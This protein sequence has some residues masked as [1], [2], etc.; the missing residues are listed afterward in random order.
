MDCDHVREAISAS[1][2]GAASCMPVGAV[3]AHLAG[4][5]GC[6]AWREAAHALT[7]H[8][9][10]G[11]HVLGHD[12]TEAVLAAA[13]AWPSPPGRGWRLG[14]WV[15]PRARRAALAAVA[16]AQFAITVPL[17]VLGRDPG[18]GEH[19][20]HELGSFALALAIAF[21]V[22]AIRPTL[23]AGLAWPCGIAAT[24]LALTAIAD[25]L[26]GETFGADE[27]QHLVAVA[28]A[29]LLLWQ[30]RAIRAGD[31]AMGA[32]AP[33]P[34]PEF[35]DQAPVTPLIT[36]ASGEPPRNNPG[37]AA[38]RDDNEEAVA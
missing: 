17:L 14:T 2:D 31:A 22:G 34:Y 35:P 33:Q 1:L 3:E 26:G 37:P 11:G 19:A 10:L 8:A 13:D 23:S 29:A 30:A 25:V 12:L 5:A 27:A 36:Q 7:R 24:G 9:R 6:R 18:A 28:G 21:A 16:L 32:P 15:V 20:A 38:R 4:C